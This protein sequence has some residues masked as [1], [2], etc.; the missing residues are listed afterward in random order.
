LKNIKAHIFSDNCEWFNLK[1]EDLDFEKAVK[2]QIRV[3]KTP[4]R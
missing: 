1:V 2:I 4:K 3:L